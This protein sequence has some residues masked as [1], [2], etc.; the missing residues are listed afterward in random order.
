MKPNKSPGTD[1]AVTVETLKF[2]GNELRNAV[3]DICNS[4]L[5]DFGVPSQW[6][7]SIIA[8]IPKKASK[9]TKYLRGIYL[10]SITAEVYNRML[11]NRIY[12]PIDKLIRPYQ[13]GFRKNRNC[14]EQIHVSRRVMEAYY[15]RKLPMTAVFIDLKKR[16]DS[17]DREM[18]WKILRNYGIPKKIV[19]AI[20]V[21]YSSNKSSVRET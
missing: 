20:A 6:T 10:M 16:F 1:F 8:P 19:N 9:A 2:G 5:N 15:Q 4:V 11:L 17:I 18:M 14:S 7:E 12:D 21:I 3:L 13:A